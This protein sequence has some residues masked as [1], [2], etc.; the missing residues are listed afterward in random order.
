MR[1]T[2]AQDYAGDVAE[3]SKGAV[4]AAMSA[5][6]AIA[7][8]KLV[9]GLLT[10]S[11]ALL[12]EAGHSVADTVNQVFLLLGINLSHTE[13]D[14]SHPHGY[15]KEPFFWS[16]LAAIFIFVAGAVFSVYE[17]TRTLIQDDNHHRTAFELWVAYGVLGMAFVFEGISFTIA[18]KQ[19]VTSAR[20]QGRGMVD[21]IRRSPDITIKTVFFEDSAAL[22]GLTIA[23]AGL[24]ASELFHTEVW[25]GV[26]SL[27]IGLLLGGVALMLGVQS[28]RLLLGAAADEQTIARIRETIATVPEVEAVVRLLTMLIGPHNVLV[29]GELQVR[30][31]LDVTAAED[32][33][34][35]LDRALA[36]AVPDIGDTFWELHHLPADA[37]QGTPFEATQHRD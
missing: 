15:G 3:E 31:G 14:A 13:A 36:E 21:Y 28:R 29:S 35:R 22:I 32:V 4:L 30:C 10:G 33:I 16:F 12:A 25:D 34:A 20:A 2:R 23:A 8:G 37:V 1:R 27:A 5:N 17:G 7:A 9:A 19:M 26:A 24:T 6:F 18:M 11:A